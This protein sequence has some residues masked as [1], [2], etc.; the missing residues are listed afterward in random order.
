MTLSDLLAAA[1]VEG[2]F[3]DV[4][5]V[6]DLGLSAT[7]IA[8]VVWFLRQREKQNA[9]GEW[10]PKRELDYTRQTFEAHLADKERQIADWRAAH[11]TSERTREILANALRES[12]EAVR[13]NERFLDSFRETVNRLADADGEH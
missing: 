4:A 3:A 8:L 9:A 10:V 1:G 11:E 13:H 7:L 5:P 2:G 6:L 12:I